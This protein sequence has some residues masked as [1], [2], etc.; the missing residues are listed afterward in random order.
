MYLTVQLMQ[1]K[2]KEEL[3]KV[4]IAMDK[5]GDGKLS[6]EELIDGF[7]SMGESHA[8]AAK[9]VNQILF[10]LDIDKNGYI[11]YSE[12]LIAMMDRKKLVTRNNLKEAFD[13]F[14][15]DKNGFIDGREMKELL[16]VGKQFSERTWTNMIKDV[17]KNADQ[18]ISFDEFE[19]MMNS[20]VK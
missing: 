6:R 4:F 12:F 13:A 15:K 14:D 18:K 2:D 17:D 8:S 10:N 1:D 7:V 3:Q 20:F 5:N 9:M 11:G 16:G 19:K